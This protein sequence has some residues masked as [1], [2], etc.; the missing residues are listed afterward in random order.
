MPGKEDQVVIPKHRGKDIVGKSEQARHPP[1][2]DPLRK[3]KEGQRK[4]ADHKQVIQRPDAQGAADVKIR[5]V[6]GTR[7]LEFGVKQFGEQVGG[8][9]QKQVH[10]HP[11]V[12][13]QPLPERILAQQR[14]MMDE[15]QQEGQEAQAVQFGEIGFRLGLLHYVAHWL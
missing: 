8:K 3:G 13:V 6:D 9:A 15:D 1:G 14:S 4:H 5:D 7:L 11:A 2:V 10:A 12:A